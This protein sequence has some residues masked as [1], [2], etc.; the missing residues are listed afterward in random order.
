M[1]AITEKTDC[2]LVIFTADG[3]PGNP[4]WQVLNSLTGLKLPRPR[5]FSPATLNL[6]VTPE[7]N[8]CFSWSL[9]QWG[10][11]NSHWRTESADIKQ[12][13]LETVTIRYGSIKTAPQTNLTVRWVST[14]QG[15]CHVTF[16]RRQEV[17]CNLTIQCFKHTH[18]KPH[19]VLRL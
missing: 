9:K 3:A 8:S 17:V 10:P 15:R 5:L 19:R 12:S 18:I 7:A 14:K 13:Q 2:T 1:F 4:G 16:L 11:G 6:Y